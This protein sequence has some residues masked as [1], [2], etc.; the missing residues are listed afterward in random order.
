MH[1]EKI[2]VSL[3]TLKSLHQH[4]GKPVIPVGTTSMRTLESLYW[5]ALKLRNGDESLIVDQWD[6]YKLKSESGF[7]MKQALE[8]LIFHVENNELSY[9]KAET[10]LMIAPGYLFKI[11]TGIITNFHQPKSTLL[12]LVSAL[13]GD[14]WEKAYDFALRNDF[15]FLSYG[16][17]CLFL[18]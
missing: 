11:A 10:Q 9:L 13:I 14:H 12:L 6:P 15:R 5:L 3:E 17:S 16:D 18:P 4:L 1:S 7:E 2:V 8:L